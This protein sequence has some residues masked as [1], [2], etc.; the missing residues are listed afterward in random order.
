MELISG[1][2]AEL[3]ARN[4]GLTLQV[5]AGLDGELDVYR[6][7][8][9]ERRVDGVIL[10]TPYDSMT[11]VARDHYPLLPVSLLLRHRFDSLSLAPKL[12]IP[13][14]CIAATQDQVVPIDHARRLFDAW[15]GPK[16]WLELPG[17]HN[18][19]DDQPEYWPAIEALLAG[20]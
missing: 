1:L 6:R 3:S 14:L 15:A 8:W 4:Y 19:T 11:A 10:V 7:W 20:H 16:R 12:S 9:A 13:L 18:N 2:E 5:V 17:G